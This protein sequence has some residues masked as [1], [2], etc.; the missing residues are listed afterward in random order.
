MEKEI[1]IKVWYMID[2]CENYI[3]KKKYFINLYCMCINFFYVFGFIVV[4]VVVGVVVN[5]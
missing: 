1:M 5:M 3:G 4:C 2:V